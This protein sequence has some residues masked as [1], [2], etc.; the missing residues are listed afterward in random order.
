MRHL[1]MASLLILLSVLFSSTHSATSETFVQCLT[2]NSD[3]SSPISSILFSP[4]S[5]LYSS[6]LEFSIQNRVFISSTTPKPQ[7]IITPLRESHI[8]AA[9]ICSKRQGLLIRVR[10][11]G[12]DYEGLSYI[13]YKPFIII[14]LVRFEKIDVNVTDK[15]A[16]VQAGATVGQV[17]YR[18]AEK[19]NTLAFPAGVCATV[20]VGGLIGGGGLGLLTRKF[21]LSTDNVLDA[22][23]IDVNGKLLN[24][25]SMGED[26]FWAIRGGQGASFGVIVSWK[27]KLV[28]VPATVTVFRVEK[29]LEQGA[30]SLFFKWQTSASKFN[31]NLLI[32]TVTEP[33]TSDGK[34]TIRVRFESTFLGSIQEL[35]PVM[36]TSFP[37]LGIEAKDCTEMPWVNTNL[38]MAWLTGQPLTI[39]LNRAQQSTN[40]FKGKSD[41]VKQA[42]SVSNLESL[43]GKMMAE[44]IS[45]MMMAEPLGGKMSEIAESATPFPHRAGNLYVIHYFISWQDGSASTRYLDSMKRLYSNMTPYVS[46]S[47]RGA[48]INYKDLDL[49]ANKGVNTSYLEARVWGEKYF[50][51]NFA[52]LAYVK[53][54]VDPENFFW[55]EL[56]I[57]PLSLKLKKDGESASM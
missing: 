16:W 2:K 40:Y 29:T 43:W 3:K 35:L 46:K 45:P 55:N 49:G 36:R 27:I 26:L 13:S 6:T 23:F 15:T 18:I 33:I 8:Q 5:S 38:F 19:S 20:G 47:P 51:G 12:H 50:K 37:E 17:Y 53:S 24:R 11:G 10:S 52:R 41:F 1:S 9:V 4:N 42:I 22:S 28:P 31:E 30:T 54:K 32:T 21:G 48:Y 44:D 7:F 34:K 25:K 56:S 57:P 14:D 39:L